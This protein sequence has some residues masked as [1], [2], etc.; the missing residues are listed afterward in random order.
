MSDK[1]NISEKIEKAVFEEIGF[2]QNVVNELKE[3]LSNVAELIEGYH[4]EMGSHVSV[5]INKSIFE[6]NF[7]CDTQKIDLDKFCFEFSQAKDIISSQVLSEKKVELSEKEK[8]KL[9]KDFAENKK[10]VL[11]IVSQVKKI[12]VNIK[13]FMT[14]RK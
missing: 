8:E 3:L 10:N 12:V 7:D 6:L 13:E 9:K 11:G 4:E 5:E 14:K 1:L 2:S